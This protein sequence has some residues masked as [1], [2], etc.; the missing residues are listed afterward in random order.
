[1]APGCFDPVHA[2]HPNIHD[3]NIRLKLHREFHGFLAVHCQTDDLDSLHT[4]KSFCQRRAD[5]RLV[6]RNENSDAF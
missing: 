4:L 6:V 5:R 3:N 1:M 2:R